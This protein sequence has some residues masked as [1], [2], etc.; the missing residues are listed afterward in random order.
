MAAQWQTWWRKRN[1]LDREIYTGPAAFAVTVVTWQRE[2][3]FIDPAV[4]SP[5]EKQLDDAAQA[6][7][8]SLLAY[9]FM[10]DHLHL[11]V[12]GSE[13]SDLPHFMKSFKQRSSFEYKQRFGT[14]LWQRS[15]HDHILRTDAEI[16]PQIAYIM[17]NPV[18]AGLGGEI[19]R[20]MLVAT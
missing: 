10:P 14:P 18:E 17:N 2:R 7:R 16:E 12:E 15:Y 4:V 19:V 6:N 1:R 13:G 9:C 20:D 3:T 8:F 11:L 5:Y